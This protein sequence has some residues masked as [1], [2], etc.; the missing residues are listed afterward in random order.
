MT[1]DG[2]ITKDPYGWDRACK[3][4]NSLDALE[5]PR[6]I[7]TCATQEEIDR[8]LSCDLP[9]ECCTGAT[10]CAIRPSGGYGQAGRPGLY[11][12]ETVGQCVK[13]GMRVSEIAR[14]LGVSQNTAQK[15][16][17]KW[18]REQV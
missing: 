10:R 7:H 18:R 2:L 3:P 5:P 1:Y 11:D 16:I 9:P 17:A 15:Y 12:P 4:W 8:C 6:K 13:A 14:R